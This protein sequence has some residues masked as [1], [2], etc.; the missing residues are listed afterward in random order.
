V[1]RID[2]YLLNFNHNV[3][4]MLYP[5]VLKEAIQQLIMRIFTNYKRIYE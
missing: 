3:I 5:L 2:F 1:N 4:Y